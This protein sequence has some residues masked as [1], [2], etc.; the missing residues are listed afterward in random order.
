MNPQTGQF[1]QEDRAE[2]WMQRVEVGEIVKIKG[3]EL[4]IVEIE[5]RHIKLKLLSVR[6]R[7]GKS[8]TALD[9]LREQLQCKNGETLFAPSK[10]R[11]T[12]NTGR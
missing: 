11:E 2:Q 3:E 10:K 8:F 12:I 1:V 9:D 4:E 6:D 7:I 5:D